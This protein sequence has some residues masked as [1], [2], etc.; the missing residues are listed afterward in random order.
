[1]ELSDFFWIDAI[2]LFLLLM[3]FIPIIN[4]W[5]FLVGLFGAFIMELLSLIRQEKLHTQSFFIA[6]AY[7]PT[8]KFNKFAIYTSILFVLIGGVLSGLFATTVS[9]AFLYGLFWEALFTFTLKGVKDG[10]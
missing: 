6:G 1:M 10:N 4:Y 9:E 5:W 8:K 3:Y 2:L 7:F